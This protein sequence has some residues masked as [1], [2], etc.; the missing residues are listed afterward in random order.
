MEV[1]IFHGTLSKK[2]NY[3]KFK[4]ELINTKKIF[5]HIFLNLQNAI[6]PPYVFERTSA[7]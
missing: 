2:I 7:P 3:Q 6:D 5:F 1:N 4:T